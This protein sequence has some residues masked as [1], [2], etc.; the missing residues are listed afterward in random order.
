MK[1]HLNSGELSFVVIF[2]HL[3]CIHSYTHIIYMSVP[4]S[5][6]CVCLPVYVSVPVCMHIRRSKTNLLWNLSS[7]SIVGVLGI[8]LRLSRFGGEWITLSHLAGPAMF[9]FIIIASFHM[10]FSVRLSSAAVQWI[11]GMFFILRN[12]N[13]SSFFISLAT[14][15]LHSTFHGCE[16]DCS[17][18]ILWANYIALLSFV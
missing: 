15:A 16:F 10:Q 18:Y 3:N 5:L 6:R 11:L 17:P 1:I 4:P 12:S 9:F 7:P 13:S 14:S 8:R 2:K